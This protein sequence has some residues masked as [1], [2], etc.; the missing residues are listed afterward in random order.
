MKVNVR[1][2]GAVAKP[3]G[4]DAFDVDVPEGSTIEQVLIASGYRKEHLKWF[5]V[6]RNGVDC[7]MVTAVSEGDEVSV[8]FPTS[9][10]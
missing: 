2:L 10:G 7:K 3:M 5:L 4:K 9:G 6:A 1:I 8:V